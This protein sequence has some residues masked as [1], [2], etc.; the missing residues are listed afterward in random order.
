MTLSDLRD[1]LRRQDVRLVLATGAEAILEL[2]VP[3]GVELTDEIL[4]IVREH[5]PTLTA[6]AVRRVMEDRLSLHHGRWIELVNSLETNEDVRFP[7]SE[8]R[9]FETIRATLDPCDA[10]ERAA[11]YEYDAGMSREAAE[12]AAGLSTVV[13]RGLVTTKT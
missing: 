7:Q 13:H 5:K 12:Q 9:A 6:W 3:N 11:I 4:A 10:E 2:D 1:W 8:I